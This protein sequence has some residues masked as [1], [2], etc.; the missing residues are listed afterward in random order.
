M[1]PSITNSVPNQKVNVSDLNISTDIILADPSFHTPSTVDLIIGADIFWDLLGS[2]SIR[3]GDGK[4]I[5]YETSLGWIVSGPINGGHVSN[6]SRNVKCNFTKLDHSSQSLNDDIQIQ[7][8]RF[9]QLEEIS[10]KSS[11]YSEEEQLCEKHFCENTTRLKDGRFCVRIPLKK[12]QDLL[13]DSFQRAKHCILSL[14][15]EN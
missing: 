15:R 10:P 8:M 12:S 13:G 5:L 11:Y 2:R 7:L 6:S 14:E 9:W 4:P 3:L 1:L